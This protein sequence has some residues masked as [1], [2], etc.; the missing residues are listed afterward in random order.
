MTSLVLGWIILSTTPCGND[1]NPWLKSLTLNIGWSVF[2]DL[3]Q[4]FPWYPQSFVSLQQTP[5]DLPLLWIHEILFIFVN[6]L[7][8]VVVIPTFGFMDLQTSYKLYHHDLSQHLKCGLKL[9]ILDLLGQKINLILWTFVFHIC[10][11]SHR[12]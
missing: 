11:P 10:I 3:D 7:I 2:D 4:S 5:R 12:T 8:L 9:W 6:S 1:P